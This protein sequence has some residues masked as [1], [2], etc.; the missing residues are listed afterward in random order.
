MRARRLLLGV[1][2]VGGIGVFASCAAEPDADALDAWQTQVSEADLPADG[3]AAMSGTASRSDPVPKDGEGISVDFEEPAV[4]SNLEFS[5]FG[6]GS[7]RVI[8]SSSGPS[9]GAGVTTDPLDCEESP[10][11]LGT[12]GMPTA[13]DG[14]TTISVDVSDSDRESAWSVVVHGD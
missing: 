13:G 8:I 2:L 9:S 1:V 5:C 4:V 10:H 12:V 11:D 7:M 6:D 14:V 3:L